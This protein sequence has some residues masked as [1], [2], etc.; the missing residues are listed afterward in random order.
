MTGL[1]EA[2]SWSHFKSKNRTT[3]R[4]G[5][6]TFT[7]LSSSGSSSGGNESKQTAT[8]T[9]SSD[10]NM[11]IVTLIM[12]NRTR[13]LETA[14]FDVIISTGTVQ[15]KDIVTDEDME[16]GRLLSSVKL[17]TTASVEADNR[18]TI[19]KPFRRL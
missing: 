11:T 15:V 8:Y 18:P 17:V 10:L 7:L 5:S 12:T 13:R 1:S 16:S 2:A 14:T 6:L 9:A 3:F 19:K 4:S